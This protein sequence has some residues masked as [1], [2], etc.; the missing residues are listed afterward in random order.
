MGKEYDS[1][2][3]A[4]SNIDKNREIPIIS[5]TNNPYSGFHQGSG[6]T[7]VAELL[8]ADLP[9]Y[10]LILID[11]IE[12]S[13]HPRAQRRLIRDLAD[14]C[15]ERELQIIISTHSPYI[16]EELPLEARLY[17]HDSGQGRQIIKGVSPEFAMTKMDDDVYPECDLYVEDNQAK[18]LLEEI[19]S[20]HGRE[21]LNRCSIVP[22]GA[23]SVGKSLGVM[24]HE[25]R[26]TRPTCIFLDGDMEA[27]NG[28]H[29]LPGEDAPERVV[30]SSLCERNWSEVWML[31]QRDVAQVGDELRCAMTERD[32]HK[33]T[34]LA[35]NNLNCTNDTL[36]KAMCAEW[37]KT[38]SESQVNKVLN[39]IREKLP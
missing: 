31:I 11:E 1:A 35:A 12:S 23:A 28:C 8:R 38:L 3:M 30:F 29:L 20:R 19:I 37:A 10:G 24:V 4:L 13:L 26:F 34:T 36:W 5:K 39:P 7:T 9:K 6:E 14:R 25:N 32:H 33:W 2:K 21:L 27:S 16:L 15:R 22:F 17:I 18:I